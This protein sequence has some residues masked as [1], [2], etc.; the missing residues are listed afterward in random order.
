M[1]ELLSGVG[2]QSMGIVKRKTQKKGHF[3]LN[4]RMFYAG[5]LVWPRAYRAALPPRNKLTTRGDVH[6]VNRP[7]DLTLPLSALLHYR[8]TK[9]GMQLTVSPDNFYASELSR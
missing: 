2:K 5:L 1:E 6:A 4:A 8:L 9:K 7:P 3:S